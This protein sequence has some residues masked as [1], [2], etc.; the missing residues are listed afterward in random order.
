MNRVSIKTKTTKEL[1][2]ETRKVI[3]LTSILLLI[4]IFGM[5]ALG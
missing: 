1:R 2:R 3:G 5:T 4:V